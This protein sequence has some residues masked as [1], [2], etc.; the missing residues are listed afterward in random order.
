[1]KL[2]F[3]HN[4][5]SDVSSNMEYRSEVCITLRMYIYNIIIL[6]AYLCGFMLDVSK[7]TIVNFL[8]VNSCKL[9]T[10]VQLFF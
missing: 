2:T 7:Y 5:G 9:S 1:M 4:L 10:V 6:S 8:E 3:V